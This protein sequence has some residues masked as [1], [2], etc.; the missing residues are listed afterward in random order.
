MVTQSELLRQQQAQARATQRSSLK[1]QQ[2]ILRRGR[3]A[4]EKKRQQ[5]AQQQQKLLSKQQEQ[6]K[7]TQISELEKIKQEIKQQISET[8]KLAK[9]ASDFLLPEYGQKLIRYRKEAE[10]IDKALSALEKGKG[11]LQN[12][13]Q[14]RQEAREYAT[15]SKEFQQAKIGT[16]RA[17]SAISRE[18]IKQQ[19]TP[20]PK[21]IEQVK[22]VEKKTSQFLQISY[23]NTL[24]GEI[25]TGYT[26]TSP[27]YEPVYQSIRSTPKQD[28]I[29][30][31]FSQSKI[32]I[33]DEP[34]IDVSNVKKDF[35]AIQ[36]YKEFDPVSEQVI[37][38]DSGV[39]FGTRQAI[40]FSPIGTYGGT[41]PI[42]YS[43]KLIEKR[44]REIKKFE[45]ISEEIGDKEELTDEEA[46][47][48]KRELRKIGGDI[49]LINGQYEITPPKIEQVGIGFGETASIFDIQ[50][51][52]LITKPSGALFETTTK[53]AFKFAGF[54]T[55]DII[56]PERTE[57]IMLPTRKETIQVDPLTGLPKSITEDIIIPELTV[58]DIAGKAKKVG[59]VAPFF[60]PYVGTGL[61]LAEEVPEFV[62]DV[63]E[64]GIVPG[65][66]K[67]AK[68]NPFELIMLGGF[69]GLKGYQKLFSPKV[70]IT[71]FGGEDIIGLTGKAD[72]V[73]V[74]SQPYKVVSKADEVI[75]FQKVMGTG[76]DI[77][78][79]SG[80]TAEVTSPF[81][82]F[83][84]FRPY[85]RKKAL[86]ELIDSGLTETQAKNL[87]RFEKPVAKEV[88][89]GGEIIT[90]YSEEG[91]KTAFEG[92]I[93]TIPKQFYF[94]EDIYKAGRKTTTKF[95]SEL[96]KQNDDFL[97]SLSKEADESFGEGFS[98][99]EYGQTQKL[100]R[101]AT[102]VK[103]GDI[104]E[105]PIFK[106]DDIVIGKKFKKFEQV[107]LS[108][109]IFKLSVPPKSQKGFLKQLGK[110]VD[111]DYADVFVEVPKKSPLRI[112][113]LDDLSNKII[114][115]GDKV[116]KTKL[117]Q[118]FVQ[119]IEKLKV[120]VVKPP[121]IRK[122][123]P[124]SV[125]SGLINKAEDVSNVL[126]GGRTKGALKVRTITKT[127]LSSAISNEL[128]S[129]AKVK[130]KDIQGTKLDFGLAQSDLNALSENLVSSQD[131]SSSQ[132]LLLTQTQPTLS[133]SDL[134]PSMF[135]TGTS[136]RPITK[137]PK[138]PKPPKK[139]PMFRFKK[140]EKDIF[141]PLKEERGY[142]VFVK[143]KGRSKKITPKPIGINEAQDLLGFTLDRSLSAT[144]SIKKT[145]KTASPSPYKIPQG[146][147]LQSFNK[148]RP[149]KVKKGVKKPLRN[150][151]IEKKTFRLDTPSEVSKI[152]ASRLLA[153]YKKP[154]KNSKKKSNKIKIGFGNNIKIF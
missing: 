124:S 153:G 30:E 123:S 88:K 68:E 48:Y 148:F 78:R 10:Y 23:R 113:Y 114:S 97:E 20:E 64:Q 129:G 87:L 1:E 70:K 84:G 25:V 32:K 91:I 90:K 77:T 118:T 50:G 116:S 89:I 81:R 61:F 134:I 146:Y 17:Q 67:Y 33:S 51:I 66:F 131:V 65:S 36:G 55:G 4:L 117:S 24:T 119:D 49:N 92:E 29:S 133:K 72:N 71:S 63:K 76:R 145:K 120:K 73:F 152:Q 128:L 80:R 85:D 127:K 115:K 151:F 138:P 108:K 105:L 19:R 106:F 103:G 110:R 86:K 96:V 112:D 38:Y 139:P 35:E 104:V 121:K 41:I 44:E 83:F 21:A 95:R 52:G 93:K 144:G 126:L 42:G 150:K 58:E 22:E 143:E 99:A 2:L 18:S 132:K 6:Q 31:I 62:S 56:I 8:N 16:L 79:L 46:K 125:E 82:E 47:R 53:G 141:K 13:S 60:I 137:P 12:I 15:G 26:P 7:K 43:D 102:K 109:D 94:G 37:A 122:P 45:E 130:T 100:S 59:E 5:E 3:E 140:K 149:Y 27:F 14:I 57:T 54:E 11:V 135:G 98:L 39:T 107:G 75:Q 40:G 147:W 34:S 74:I 101:F 154:K 69:V 136:P 111:L 28:F 9:S 142:N